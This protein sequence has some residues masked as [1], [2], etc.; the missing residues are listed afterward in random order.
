MRLDR[1]L[2]F[3][4]LM[5]LSGISLSLLKELG[6]QLPISVAN[7]LIMI[8]G[9]YYFFKLFRKATKATYIFLIYLSLKFGTNLV[10]YKDFGTDL[11]DL[12]LTTIFVKTKSLHATRLKSALKE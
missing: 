1:D 2:I 6:V 10:L 3:L 12:L 9:P 4:L 5:S 8:Y 7:I 11:R